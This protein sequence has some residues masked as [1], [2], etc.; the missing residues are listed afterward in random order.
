ML[1]DMKIGSVNDTLTETSSLENRTS[2]ASSSSEW[3]DRSRASNSIRSPPD[4]TKHNVRRESPP[5]LKDNTEPIQRQDDEGALQSLPSN[6]GPRLGAPNALQNHAQ[7]NFDELSH[8]RVGSPQTS[9]QPYRT[10]ST[11]RRSG[12]AVLG[13][14]ELT[15]A[16]P[17]NQTPM[18]AGS[19]LMV[20]MHEQENIRKRIEEIVMPDDFYELF[21]E[22][23]DGSLHARFDKYVHHSNTFDPC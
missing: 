2:N 4:A 15:A 12:R 10:L 14:L 23:I 21:N 18:D 13:S 5:L 3:R 6:N 8:S 20:T 22:S 7:G 1:S 9:C 16:I 11:F 19:G 17:T